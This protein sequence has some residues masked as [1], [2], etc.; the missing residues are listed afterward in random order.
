MRE[1]E[2][3]GGHG[4]KREQVD[5]VNLTKG[6]NRAAYLAARL[7]RD[8]PEIA[9]ALAARGLTQEQIAKQLGGDK[10][11]VCRW[12]LQNTPGAECTN[13]TPALPDAATLDASRGG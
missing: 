3:I 1:A 12:L 7:K 9:E 5:N 13:D 10:S 8:A 4:G 11:T 2:A 6:G